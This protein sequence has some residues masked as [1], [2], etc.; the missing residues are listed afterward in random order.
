MAD[1]E[2]LSSSERQKRTDQE[3]Q[4]MADDARR[5]AGDLRF[6]FGIANIA[7]PVV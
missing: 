6:F 2:I 7:V 4:K 3:R 1:I 5:M